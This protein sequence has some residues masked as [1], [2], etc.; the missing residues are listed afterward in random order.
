M[1]SSGSFL[2]YFGSEL[3]L[4]R[5][6]AGLTQ[7]DVGQRCYCGNGLISKIERA[8]R[9]PQPDLCTALDELFHTDGFFARLGEQVREHSTLSQEFQAYVLQEPRAVAISTFVTQLV[10]GLL[11][12][13]DYARLVISAER[14]PPSADVIETRLAARMTRQEIL[15]RTE[16]APPRFWAVMSEAVLHIEVGSKK[17]MA[18][19][20]AHILAAASWPNV[21]IQVLP[22]AAGVT[23]AIDIPFIVA[24]MP[25]G[26]DL[27]HIDAL[28]GI[29]TDSDGDTITRY[30]VVF[31]HLRAAALPEA[32]SGRV[33]EKTMKEYA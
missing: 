24:E 20:L 6:R 4:H 22:F 5:E 33:I 1:D 13:E 30:R 28:P 18:E 9:V 26:P 17:A 12:T 29:R 3:R 31:D 10:P 11:Q 21:T 16:P 25:D 19:Q 23:P 27:F 32:A 7:A 2:S 14:P 15:T 8:E